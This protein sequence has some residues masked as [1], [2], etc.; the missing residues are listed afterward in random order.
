MKTQNSI[1]VKLNA[2]KKAT[3]TIWYI[4]F[5]IG[6]LTIIGA[7]IYVGLNGIKMNINASIPFWPIVCGILLLGIAEIFSYGLKLQQ[8]NNSMV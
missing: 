3:R 1:M 7:S 6:V 4:T 8:D 5:G 2:Y